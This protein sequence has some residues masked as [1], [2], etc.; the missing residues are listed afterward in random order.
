MHWQITWQRVYTWLAN[1][2]HHYAA[3]DMALPDG[4]YVVREPSPAL[5]EQSQQVSPANFFMD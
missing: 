5:G 1:S 2:F 4:L 3:M